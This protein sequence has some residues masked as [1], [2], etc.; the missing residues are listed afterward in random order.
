MSAYERMVFVIMVI[1]CNHICIWGAGNNG[2]KMYYYL[3]LQEKNNLVFGDNNKK[4]WGRVFDLVECVGKDMLLD[5]YGRSILII[6]C[7]ANQNREIISDLKAVGFENVISD[8]NYYREE[9]LN[10]ALRYLIK[11]GNFDEI[12]RLSHEYNKKLKWNYLR[13]NYENTAGLSQ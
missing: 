10:P 8:E 6:V 13:S 9:P 7:T 2:L 5:R 3:K 1:S 4:K 11:E 12:N